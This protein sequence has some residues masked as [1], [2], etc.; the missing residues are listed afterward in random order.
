[1]NKDSK[2]IPPALKDDSHFYG[3]CHLTILS[4]QQLEVTSVH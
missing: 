1:M 2:D 4:K 3:D